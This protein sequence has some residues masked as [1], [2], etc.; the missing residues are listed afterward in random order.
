MPD[1]PENWFEDIYAGTDT[2]GRG[3]P[4]AKLVP[5][6]LLVKWLDR[7]WP[8]GA[9]D[10]TLVVGCGLGDDAAELARRGFAV[11]A[12]DVSASAIDLCRERYPDLPVTWH[13]SELFATPA[14]WSRAFELVVEH[15]TVQ[16]LPPQWQAPG[17]AAIADFVAPGGTVLVIAD[18]RPDGTEPAGPPWRL[19]PEELAAFTAAGLREEDRITSTVPHE[20]KRQRL[21]AVFRRDENWSLPRRRGTLNPP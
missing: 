17:M 6:P 20:P 15:R 3:V 8:E 14:A 19:R 18:L 16:S 21:V 5:A 1:A 4:W 10:P 13:V 12:F 9:A 7:H 2:S 11:T